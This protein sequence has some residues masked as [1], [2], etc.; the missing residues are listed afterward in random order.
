MKNGVRMFVWTSFSVTRQALRIDHVGNDTEAVIV[1]KKRQKKAT[2]RIRLPIILNRRE[3]RK[4]RWGR[5][6]TE[7][8]KNM[9]DKKIGSEI[10]FLP[11]SSGPSVCSCSKRLLNRPNDR[12]G[13]NFSQEVAKEAELGL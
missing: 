2:S 1:S 13:K 6:S 5:A 7:A 12:H 9:D 3:R 8:D 10:I 11:I 4:Q